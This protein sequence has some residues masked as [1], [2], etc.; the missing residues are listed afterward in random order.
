MLQ[1]GSGVVYTPQGTGAVVIDNSA[2]DVPA[3]WHLQRGRLADPAK[4]TL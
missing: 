4:A 3:A 1:R 2:D